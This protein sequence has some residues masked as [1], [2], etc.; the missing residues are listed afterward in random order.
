[1]QI[2]NEEDLLKLENKIKDE[3]GI[4]VKQYRNEEVAENIVELLILPQYI[5]N[6]IVRPILLALLIYIA[7]FFFLDLVHI[8]YLIYGIIG[9]GLF[10]FT[11]VLIG[12]LLLIWK[13]KSDVWSIIEYSLN[14]MNSAIGDLNKVNHQ[15]DGENKKYVLGLLFQGITHIVI[16]PI[17]SH[18]MSN[19]IPVVGGFL[20]NTIIKVLT[21]I[22]DKSDFEDVQL[23]EELQQKETASNTYEAY[24][25]SISKASNG[26]E[27]VMNFTF[28]VAQIPLWIATLFSL[29]ILI[30]FILLIG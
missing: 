17:L 6:W 28:R 1:M 14:M 20:K 30:L 25:Q 15:I 29:S 5:F 22:S 9:F 2:K 21:S 11:G 26:I 27:K 24:E 10:F 3:L 23:K 19:K 16:I 8:E 4:D 12:L 13:M 7:G 18:G